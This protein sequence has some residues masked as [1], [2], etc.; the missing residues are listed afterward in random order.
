MTSLLICILLALS[1]CEYRQAEPTAVP[2]VSPEQTTSPQN[3][4]PAEQPARQSEPPAIPSDEPAVQDKPVEQDGIEKKRN[5]PEGFV[6]VDE[7]IPKALF[8]IRY[9]SDYNFVGE[10]IAGYNAPVPI[11]TAQAAEAL[12]KAS[13]ELDEQGYAFLIYDGYRP[14]KAV[15]HFTAWAK[16]ARDTKMKNEFYPDV[17]KTKVFKLGYVASRSGHSRGSTVDLTIVHRKTGDPVDMGSPFDFF[18]EIS[19]HGTKQITAEQTDNRNILKNVMVKYGF[20]PYNKEWWHYTLKN[21]PYPDIYFDFD[22][23]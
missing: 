15:S 16:D 1:S 20:K 5:L 23:E 7:A 17:D 6:Y 3:E 13:E 14:K 9:Y 22:V 12:R 18:G 11:L 8:E 10:R 4:L 21:E 2:V 19:S